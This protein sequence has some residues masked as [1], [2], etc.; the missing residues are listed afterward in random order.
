[1][2]GKLLDEEMQQLVENNQKEIVMMYELGKEQPSAMQLR[3]KQSVKH[4]SKM[5]VDGD[6]DYELEK[7]DDDMEEFEELA[8]SSLADPTS[9]AGVPSSGG[10]SK[11]RSGSMRRKQ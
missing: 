5:D 1:M 7:E 11:K 10:G 9:S 4:S 3:K 8:Q 2:T 6:Y